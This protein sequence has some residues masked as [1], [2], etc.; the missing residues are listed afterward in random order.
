MPKGRG[1]MASNPALEPDPGS[2]PAAA[3]NLRGTRV[4]VAGHYGMVGSAVCRRLEREG[5]ELLR[6]ARNALDFRRQADVERWM[7]EQ[8]PEVVIVAA[9]RVGGVYANDTRPA[10]FLYDNLM[11]E[12]NLVEA[13][14]RVGVRKL[15][16]LGSS[17][18][19]P[20]HAPQPIPEAALLSGPLEPTN[21]WYAVAKIAGLK[22]VEAYR[23]QYGCDYI[24]AQPANL[25]GPGDNFD[26]TASHVIPALIRKA[27]DARD[28]GAES[29]TV[30]GS[31]TP[32]RE[33]LH[34]DDL[35]DA[36]VFL[37]RHYS[38]TGIV[39]VGS[40]QETT[41]RTLAET[42]CELVGFSGTLRFDADK[43]DGVMRKL[44]DSSKLRALGWTAPTQLRAGLAQ[45]I[46]WFESTGA[47]ARGIGPG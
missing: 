23:R 8:R 5:S 1:V 43:P 37:T 33:F 10:E 31:G 27:I 46:A 29:L 9:A 34:V 12:A 47:A 20:A 41:I 7:A 11:I 15:V 24:S 18:I 3:F 17:C 4:F 2:A 32:L 21:Q 36:I 25:Y 44:V 28:S 6:V 39:N 16:F 35:A 40:G 14:H 13:A 19:Y 22:L 30:W 26:L 38:D 45:T 42:I